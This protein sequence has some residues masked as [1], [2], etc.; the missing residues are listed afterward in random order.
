MAQPQQLNRALTFGG[1]AAI[2]TGLAFAA[3]N[4]LSLGQMLGYVNPGLAWLPVLLGGVLVLGV[5]ALFAELNGM[6][7]SAAA[8]RLWLS[9]AF[10]PRIALIIT[11]TYASAI[12]LVV[13]ADA[14]I[15]GEAIA[16]VLH[17]GQWVA[18][19]YV[20]ALLAV[21]T[22]INLRGIRLAGLAE[23]VVTG[24]AVALTV[25]V[26]VIA[27]AHPGGAH[28]VPNPGN[29]TLLQ[30]IILGVFVY[31][32]FEWITASAEEVVRP[33]I[34]PRAML[35]A[36]GVLGVSQALFAWA[37]GRT[38]TDTE[39]TS[40]YPQMLVAQRSIGQS[41]LVL[42]LIVTAL[43]AINT[44]NAGFATL[45]RFLYAT[46][47]EGKLPP[48]LTR[49]NS[50]AV[51]VVPIWLLGGSS[52]ALA[53]VVAVT[54]SFAVMVSVGAALEAFIYA[55]AGIVVI[56]LRR[57]EPDRERPYRMRG[58]TWLP[59]ALTV[60]FGLFALI[61]SVSVGPRISPVPLVLM[62]VFAGLVTVYAYTYLPRLER[63]AEAEAAARRAA[64][65]AARKQR[66]AR[67][68]SR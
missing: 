33:T 25:L 57:R 63:R 7:P 5:R 56:R 13:A 1:A 40:A 58:G 2:S 18:I 48:V 17:N 27:I 14:F 23:Q 43:T 46:A 15:I 19:A 49:L 59:I 60:L 42:M 28:Q 61:A 45:S 30:A 38:L 55:A 64:R 9:R 41:G 52:L 10:N 47:R 20:A 32:G 21:A 29:G 24:V 39:L 36:L 50:R 66:A 26:A 8:I 12:V 3:I 4:F 22:W 16:Y 44:F 53:V 67:P 68:K 31:A 51:P 65:A 54:D 37:M 35:V 6:H 11:L 34:I 62:V